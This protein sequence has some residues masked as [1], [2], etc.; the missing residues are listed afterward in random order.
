MLFRSGAETILLSDISGLSITFQDVVEFY[1]DKFKYRLRFD[2]QRH[3][4]VKLF[5]DLLGTL[6]K[7]EH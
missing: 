5:Y 1:L 6:V 4:S 7:G 3:M 2:P